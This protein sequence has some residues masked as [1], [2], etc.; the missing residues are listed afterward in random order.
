MGGWPEMPEMLEMA[1]NGV[2]KGVK[3]SSKRPFLPE[4]PSTHK[5]LAAFLPGIS[6]M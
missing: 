5:E 2:Q 6:A 1:G 4:P 3:N